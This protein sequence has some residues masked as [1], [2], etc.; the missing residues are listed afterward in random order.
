MF[1]GTNDCQNRALHLFARPR[2][3]RNRMHATIMYSPFS[4]AASFVLI[5]AANPILSF[6]MTR[7]N[8]L[9]DPSL[10]AIASWLNSIRC[11]LTKANLQYKVDHKH[12]YKTNKILLTHF[13]NGAT[14]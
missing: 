4:H 5:S 8:I 3:T 10:L 11:S 13:I 12:L 1:I 7:F 6:G 14:E 9:S 2:A